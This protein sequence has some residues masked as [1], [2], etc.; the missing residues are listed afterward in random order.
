VTSCSEDDTNEHQEHSWI[1]RRFRP[2]D[3]KSS[4]ASCSGDCEIGPFGSGIGTGYPTNSLPDQTQMAS[5][6]KNS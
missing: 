1:P 5:P 6:V 2:F 3:N 4:F